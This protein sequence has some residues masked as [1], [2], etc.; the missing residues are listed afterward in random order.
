MRLLLFIFVFISISLHSQN[1][2]FQNYST[3]DG[4]V[5]KF[6]YNIIRDSEGFVWIATSNG[7]SRFD[8]YSFKNYTHQEG[9]PQ[10]LQGTAVYGLTEGRDNKIWLSTDAGL[11]YFDKEKEVFYY[12][13]N[14]VL[15]DKFFHKD[16][17]IDEDGLVWL[18]N[19]QTHFVV[20]DLVNDS[21]VMQI[22]RLGGKTLGKNLTISHFLVD[23]GKI[24]IA[25]KEEKALYD[26][27]TK[28]YKVLDTT[29]IIHCHTIRKA[30]KK[31]IVIS[32]M[33]DGIYIIDIENESGQWIKKDFIESKIGKE[34]AFFD[35]VIDADGTVWASVNPG[36][37]S[38][39][40]EAVNYYNYDS[41]ELYFDGYVVSCFH[42][43]YDDN[44]WV[45]SYEHGIFLKKNENF[46]YTS[47]L[48]KDDI[49]KTFM[50]NFSV[51]EDNSLL[52]ADA[53]GI[54]RCRDYQHLTINCA[55]R[56][57]SGSSPGL[58]PLDEK[59]CLFS[60]R[61]TLYLYNSQDVSFKQ[62]H[63][64][65]AP[66][67]S[68]IDN[69]SVIWVGSWNGDL[70]G[71]D[72]KNHKKY[73][74][75]VDKD[76]LTSFPLF[77]ITGT[78]NGGLWLGTFGLGLVY[79]EAPTSANPSIE[80]YN[81][82]NT[83]NRYFN[84]NN[85]NCL[86]A[87]KNKHL[88]IGTNGG[89]LVKFELESDQQTVYSTENGLK[90]NAIEAITADEDGN[91][92]F[93]SNVL[94]KYDVD[95][96]SFTHYSEG[97]GVKGSF[98]TKSFQKSVEGDLIFANADGIYTF[99]PSQIEIKKNLTVP[100]LTGFQINGIDV[101]VG[102]SVNEIIPVPEKLEFL[103]QISLPYSLNSFAVEFTS[104]NYHKAEIIQYQYQL[105]GLD[106][107]WITANAKKRLVN[108]AGINHGDYTFKVK[109]SHDGENWSAVKTLKIEILPPWWQTWIFKISLAVFIVISIFVIIRRRMQRIIN[110]KTKLEK[111][112]EER[113]SELKESNEELETNAEELKS[114]VE[115][116]RESKVV[117]EMKNNQLNEAMSSKDR[118]I[119]ILAHDFKNPLTGILGIAKLLEK[120]SKKVKSKT[121][122]Q[123]SETIS[124]SAS[125]LTNQMI[126][127][128][129]WVYSQEKE[130]DANPVEINIEV[131]L[132]DAIA[133]LLSSAAE[134]NITLSTQ[135]D[136]KM[137]VLAD[138][139][140][141]SM[142]FRNIISNAI[143]FTPKGGSV[144]VMVQ[145]FD[146]GIDTSIIDTGVGMKAEVVDLVLNQKEKNVESTFGTNREK[147]TGLGVRLSQ[148]FLEKNSG[149]LAITSKENE[150][151]VFTISLPKG[152]N[153]AT[154]I[155]NVETVEESVQDAERDKNNQNKKA[156]KKNKDESVGEN[157]ILVIEDNDEILTVIQEALSDNYKVVSATNGKTGFTVANNIL[158]DLI[159]S[160]INL[161]ELSGIEV[162]THLKNNKV[163]SH[164]PVILITSMMKS[165][166]KDEAYKCGANDFIEKPLNLEHLQKKI[167]SLFD[168]R[169]KI[170]NKVQQNVT[171]NLYP[172]L[173][174]DFNNALIN[175]AIEYIN[176]N[177]GN[178]KLNTNA[179]AEH[180]GVSRTQLWRVFK[181]V[182]S[183]SLGDYIKDIRMQKAS[184][185]LKTG[186][187]R[188]SDIAFE[189]GYTDPRYFSRC[190]TKE[191]GLSPSEYAKKEKSN[192]A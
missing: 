8:S 188:I 54:Y 64:F 55:E 82:K 24:W 173:P 143:K 85:I 4:L 96:S 148:S 144:F 170:R 150:G 104:I 22:D 159:I 185:M 47:R 97:E 99:S 81:N 118:L 138:P 175:K 30:G 39:K 127:V 70:L 44:I 7:L 65:N 167:D 42:R 93:T 11:E 145:E 153:I 125:S 71:Y 160:D 63:V 80:F 79:I 48:H 12:V 128:L 140:M 62:F 178:E 109:A 190:F 166:V 106:K 57:F 115:N 116:L 154:K 33:H 77:T 20:Y 21:V 192:F 88:W 40:G 147:G 171:D 135:F 38:V 142:V 46:S 163:T 41:K 158:P 119:K 98:K 129:D 117:I 74:I 84:V 2:T 32:D 27:K 15:K 94:S 122:T 130:L 89:G 13:D 177:V 189:V 174:E 92:W 183:K 73:H 187:Y 184:S 49:H 28:E 19:P 141:I 50:N 186:K 66:A 23:K 151:S 126:T 103:E 56:I 86:Y 146:H 131:L 69:D 90:S 133:L 155:V 157:S 100:V 105:E 107:E 108:Y 180:L 161:P 61:D 37:V 121:I 102:D 182:S 78:E 113:T 53:N 75:N 172:D 179:V 76:S 6:V 91:I 83:G 136:Y 139:R 114:H 31:N 112:V 25:G 168:Y 191:F 51:F 35:A 36:V 156:G 67:C 59:T 29:S 132:N 101:N 87:D 14:E 72:Q 52:Y 34:V 124:R 110:E 165:E 16:I 120:E 43:D 137:N 17:Y 149:T 111:L 164:I 95:N 176:N 9:D 5:H 10:S 26:I 58:F 134:K 152:E 60:D 1:I 162:C 123:Y 169:N 45:G 3:S 181:S 68:Y 18:Y